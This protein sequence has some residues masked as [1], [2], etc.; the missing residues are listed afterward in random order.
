M[1]T[2]NPSSV[3]G[4]EG[5]ALSLD[6]VCMYLRSHGATIVRSDDPKADLPVVQQAIS[7][8]DISDGLRQHLNSLLN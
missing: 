6:M 7:T 3:S 8:A 4:K 2:Q 5:L 1:P